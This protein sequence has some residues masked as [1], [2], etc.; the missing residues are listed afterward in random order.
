ME[1][2]RSVKRTKLLVHPETSV[3]LLNPGTLDPAKS[4]VKGNDVISTEVSSS[5]PLIYRWIDV[6]R[7]IVELIDSLRS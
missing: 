1:L 4:P 6:F 3:N 2:Y 7:S 5:I